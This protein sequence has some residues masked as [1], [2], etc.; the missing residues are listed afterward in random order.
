MRGLAIPVAALRGWQLVPRVQG[1][2]TTCNLQAVCHDKDSSH[3]QGQQGP[4]D[5]PAGGC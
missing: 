2:R 3:L 5:N 4:V 1:L